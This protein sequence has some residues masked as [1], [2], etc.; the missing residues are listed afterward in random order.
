MLPGATN[1]K[2]TAIA[3]GRAH[4]QN[5][6]SGSSCLYRELALWRF[7]VVRN[8]Y[9]A[10]ALLALGCSAS[11]ATAGGNVRVERAD[12]PEN[13]E[14]ISVLSAYASNTGNDDESVREKL[15]NQAA[16]SGANYV[17]L[18]KLGGSSSL[19]EYTGT[20]FKCPPGK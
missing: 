1:R 3:H 5:L 2:T 15:R 6:Q 4:E 9:A 13:C 7:D 19:K 8:I 16:I 18:D 14:Q 12:P 20:A 17:R 11:A 10:C